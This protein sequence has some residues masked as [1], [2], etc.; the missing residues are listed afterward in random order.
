MADIPRDQDDIVRQTDS[1][2]EEVSIGEPLAAFFEVGLE[3]SKALRTPFVETQDSQSSEELP[4]GVHFL[5][6]GT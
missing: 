6:P 3:A 2:D 1:A 5:L 4:H